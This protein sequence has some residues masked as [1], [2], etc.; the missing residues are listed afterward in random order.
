MVRN[1]R[2]GKAWQKLLS[3]LGIV[4]MIVMLL[5]VSAGTVA[6]DTTSQSLMTDYLPTINET[7]DASGFKHPGVG[8]TKEILEN[9]QTEVRAQKEPWMTYFNQ[10]TTSGTASRT[11][12]SSKSGDTFNSQGFNGGFIADG[13]KAYTQALTYVITGDEVYRANAMRIIRNWEQMDPTK[14]AYFTDAH[15]HTGIP[16]YRMVTAAEILRY[17]S[18]QTPELVWTD[19][20]TADFTNNLIVPVTET[21]NHTNYRFMNQHLYPLIGSVSGYIFSGNLGR[22]QEAVE[23]FTVNKTAVDQYM[24]G[25]IKQL[26]RLVDTNA[27]TGEKVDTPQVQIV[28]MGRDQAHSTGDVINASI[29]SRLLQA[30]GTKVDPVNGTVST[31]ENAVSTYDFLGKRIL[32]GADHFARYMLGYDTPWIP[33]E[34]RIDSDGNPVIYKILSS[35]YRGRIGG[36]VYDLYYYYKYEQGLDIEQA[37]PYFA[38]MFKKKL[39]YYW[40]SPDAGGEY[41][42]YIPK[43]AE[44]EGATYLPKPQIGNLRE[45][46]ARFTRFD[47]NSTAMQEGD[48]SFV[49]ITATETGSKLALVGSESSTRAIGYKIRTNGVAKLEAFGQTIALPDTKGQWRYVFYNLPVFNGL[50]NLSYFTVIGNGTAVDIDH[51]NVNAAN[52]LTPP[53]FTAGAAPLKLFAY[54]GSGATLHYEFSAADAGPSDVVTYQIDN[55]PEGTVFHTN[56]G[57]FEWKPAKAGTYAFVVEA[58]D[59][60]TIS[61]RDVTVIVTNDRQSAVEAAIAP[62]N[63]NIRYVWSTLDAYNQAYNSAVNAITG[64]TD[65]VFYQK[66]K[67]LD[68]AVQGL[69]ETTPL[70]ADGSMNYRDM[71][72]SSTFTAG[73]WLDE[74]PDTFVAYTTAQNLS[75]FMD[76]GP[77]FRVSAQAFGLQVRAGFPERI[78]GVAVFG[79]NDYENWT[80]LTPEETIVTSDMQTLT[81]PQELRNEQFRFLKIQMVKPY[82]QLFAGPPIIELSE[83]RIFGERHEVINKLSKVSIGSNQAFGGRIV[84]GDTVK[85][86]FQSTENIQNLNVKIQGQPATVRTDDGRTWTAEAVMGPG[87]AP[88]AVKFNIQYQTASG[89]IAAETLFTTDGSRLILADES[90]LIRDI[91]SIAAVSDSYGRSPADAI[92][93]ANRL[94][95][96]NPMTDTDY[97]LNGSGAGSWVQFDFGQ[98]GYAQLSYVELLARQDG[99]FSRI[100]GTV[101]QGSND[102]ATWKTISSAAVPTK[103]WQILSINDKQRYRYIRMYNGNAWF[104]NMSEVRFH[105]AMDYDTA[106]FDS[107]VVAPDGYTK[108]SYYLYQQK[109]NQIRAEL[110]QPDVNKMAIL[111]QLLEAKAILVPIS[112]INQKV[113]ITPSMVTASTVSWDGKYT[114][115]QNGWRAFDGDQNTFPDTKTAAGWVTVDLGAENAKT[116]VGIKYIPRSGQASRM[117]GAIIQGSKDGFTYTSIYTISGVTEVKWYTQVINNNT[118][119]RYLRYYSS[120]GNANVGELEFY[121]KIVDRT[122][123]T[124]L[125]DQADQVAADRYTDDSYA[126]LQTAVS[127]AKLVVSNATATQSDL[128]AAADSLKTALDSLIYKI[129]ASLD[130]AEPNGTND[131]Y[132]TPITVTLSTYGK[133]EYSFDDSGM[134]QSYSGPVTLNQDGNYSVS[135]RSRN[136][137]GNAGSVQTVA[138][139]LDAT[140]P[141]I[142]VTGLVYGSYSNAVDLA[143]ALVLGDNLSGVDNSKT[144]VTLDTYGMQPGTTVPLYTLPLG[145]HTLIVTA[146]DLAGNT[147]SKTVTFESKASIESMKDLVARFK[148]AGWIDNA[149]I[150][151]SLQSKLAANSLAAFVNE[152]Q[153]QSGK[154]IYT[155]ASQYLLRDAGYLLNNP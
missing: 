122:L 33:T 86:S 153:A 102:N 103:D 53:L 63:A 120:T 72:V 11:V 18:T 116:I 17:S 134:W 150:A 154:H 118:P 56:T 42:L 25:S 70:L 71:F 81:V 57:I 67:D 52:E 96:N 147:S 74:S 60:T 82:Y 44:A 21:F 90:D 148:N 98:G 50:N 9:L 24:N 6:A 93:I 73:T 87:S 1:R 55:A 146:N 142:T 16:L 99:Y 136:E 46:E 29:L 68:Q 131:W 114:A 13:L 19:K 100:N 39:P 141:T 28:E 66:L 85:L 105:G 124:F 143:P 140:A 5:P 115:G 58:S 49:R 149:G 129:A 32:Q 113:A 104:G 130:P 138:V 22:Y 80:R 128:D 83:F 109:V 151:N 2:S 36:N 26:F 7:I 127:N 20:D 69:R 12:T 133:A 41:W 64:A 119:Y 145:S 111:N 62:Y 108:L 92:A 15:I 125:L 38:E 94:F 139:N 137:A 121:E 107:K 75:H 37:A 76:F 23:W 132:T 84:L 27:A 126:A 47:G 112:F 30:Q 34:A 91:T 101:I 123:L 3:I 155:Q 88:G 110:E 79:S 97:R 61:T 78:G 10:M 89:I 54:V 31:A 4:S 106:Y 95:D 14:Y 51:I 59:G 43:E 77:S 117:N 35:N 45:I 40:E 144:T 65:E 48:V 135:Y 8:L 152:V